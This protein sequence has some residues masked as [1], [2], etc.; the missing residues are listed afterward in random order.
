MPI[1]PLI[2]TQL[3]LSSLQPDQ[4]PNQ[5][6]S[7]F[8]KADGNW[9]ELVVRA[10]VLGL[11]PQLHHRLTQWQIALPPAASG[12]LI[13]T[14]KATAQRY[15]NIEAQLAEVLAACSIRH[16]QPIALKGVHLAA[17]YYAQ[18]A[19]RP[20]NDIDLLF[21]PAD[22]PTA[23]SIL[24]EL[25]Y[26]GKHK[27]AEL[28]AGVTKH[29]ST[30]R[31]ADAPTPTTP[32]P[33]LSTTNDRII[34]PHVSLEESWFG[35]KVDITPGIWERAET[36]VL[37]NYPCLVLSREDLLLHVCL[38]FCFHLIQGAPAMV[39]FTDI[40]AITQKGG[41]DWRVF[42]E[43]TREHRAAPYALAA[44]LLAAKLLKAPVPTGPIQA[45][46]LLTPTPLRQRIEQFGL[47]D[48]L[49]RTQQKPLTSLPLRLKRGFQDRAETAKWAQDWNG[50]FAVW[51][52]LFQPTKTDTGQLLI[53]KLTG[54]S[55]K[56]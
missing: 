43:R 35:L 6:E 27:S 49:N 38:H 40:L 18:P 56:K 41:L 31:R 4:T 7:D 12:K 53:K 48:I 55:S 30:F 25:G 36:A 9:D 34:E 13:V 15:Q 3:I 20:M 50:R 14:S 17:C 54:A 45:L 39:Q 16:I 28:G 42:V 23:E 32:N 29:T 11:A 5:W 46:S 2:S 1:A 21:T 10:I 26:G 33:Y 52:T 22:L 19:L 37:A 24:T 51:R 47:A 44:L 8:V